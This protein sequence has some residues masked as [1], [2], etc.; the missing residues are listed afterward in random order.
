MPFTPLHAVFAYLANKGTRKLSLPAL[1]VSSMLPDLEIPFVYLMTGGLYGRLF[2]HSL[3]GVATLGTF[4]SVLL[5]FFLYPPV[6]SLVFRLDREK[7]E[8]ECRFSSMLLMSCLL[9]CLSHVLIDS[10]HHEYNPLLYPLVNESFDSFVLF[11]NW[12][13][14]SSVVQFALLVLLLLILFWEVGKGTR[15][16]WKRVLVG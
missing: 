16:F 12:R 13:L 2:L 6:V 3:L 4:L 9:G 1:I 15:G 11:N 8:E 10:L 7:V 5:T 14:A